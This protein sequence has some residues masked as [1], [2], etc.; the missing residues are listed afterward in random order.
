MAGITLRK[1]FNRFAALRSDFVKIADAYGI[2][3][4]KVRRKEEVIPAIEKAMAHDGPFLI[5]FGIE[6]EENVY[7]FVRRELRWK[8]S[9]KYPRRRKHYG[10]DKAH[11]SR[12][13]WRINP[14]S[15]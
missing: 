12:F 1:P 8:S 2:S 13:W 5:D 11:A 9:W 14:V 6:P 3:G 15:E 10:N 7:P 4:A